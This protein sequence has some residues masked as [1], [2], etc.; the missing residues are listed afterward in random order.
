MAPK[1]ST[2]ATG[3]AISPI[4]ELVGP[5]LYMKKKTKDNQNYTIEPC[6]TKSVL[7]EAKK[8]QFVLLYFSASWCPPCQSF[9]PVLADFYQQH[10]NVLDIIY[11]P[12]DRTKEEFIEYYTKKMPWY[13][14]HPF[15]DTG[16]NN[17][18]TKND[19]TN[20]VRRKL[21]ITFQI[22]GIPTL[23]VLDKNTGY[24]IT[25][26]GRM[27][28]LNN[29]IGK[30]YNTIIEKW[31]SKTPVP[32]EE[33]I[34]EANKIYDGTIWS[35]IK[36]AFQWLLQNPLYIVGLFY[37]MKLFMKSKSNNNMITTTTDDSVTISDPLLEPVPEDEF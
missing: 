21:A 9:T 27:D 10:S 8:K 35:I 31:K 2:T 30:S 7:I 12:S 36:F 16:T 17:D 28:L 24:F 5:T 11:I 18:A 6:T 33:G 26:N 20:E 19:A 15:L 34:R 1:T 13:T 3:T 4:V 23:I 32:I 29:G 22:K 37:F 25:N 14:L